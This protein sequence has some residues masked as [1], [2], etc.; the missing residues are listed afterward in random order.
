MAS[1]HIGA[2]NVDYSLM[3]GR[4]R[5]FKLDGTTLF[6]EDM[7]IEADGWRDKLHQLV[8]DYSLHIDQGLGLHAF[9]P[10]VLDWAG[11]KGAKK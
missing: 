6:D 4:V 10:A 11:K 1:L 3:D 5:S 8:L 7:G 2:A 9:V